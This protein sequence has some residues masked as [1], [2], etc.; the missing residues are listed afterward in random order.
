MSTLP[1]DH[2]LPGP[3]PSTGYL[4]PVLVGTAG[5]VNGECFVLARDT[6][7]TVGRSRSCQVS[8]CRMHAYLAAPETKREHD[9]DFNT[10][11]RRHV[12]IVVNDS[13][14]SVQDLSSQGTFCDGEPIHHSKH[15][16]LHE[17]ACT[18]RLGSRESFKL[19]LLSIDDPAIKERQ[20]ISSQFHRTD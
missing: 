17:G 18:V 20:T 1:N 16:N 3:T 14:A 2:K 7:I 5:L 9:I 6:E 11:S 12:R 10:V 8:L 15:I 4:V 13:R 19:M